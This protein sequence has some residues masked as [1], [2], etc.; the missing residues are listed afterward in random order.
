MQTK[1]KDRDY[2]AEPIEWRSTRDPEF[3][4]ESSKDG[5]SLMIR[6]NDF[7][8]EH[9]YS[10]LVEGDPLASFDDWPR[11]WT[12]NEGTINSSNSETGL[13]TS[14]GPESSHLLV[15]LPQ[16]PI[17][18]FASILTNLNEYYSFNEHRRIHLSFYDSFRERLARWGMKDHPS[19]NPEHEKLIKSG[20]EA[21]NNWRIQH[22]DVQPNLSGVDLTGAQ[23]S[24]INLSRAYLFG[25]DLRKSDLRNARLDNA[26]LSA[27]IL[28]EANLSGAFLTN[29]ILTLTN[30]DYANLDS[31]FLSEIKSFR[32]SFLGAT[33]VNTSFSESSLFETDFSGADLRECRLTYTRFV[34]SKFR[35]ANLFS[36]NVYGMSAWDMDVSNAFQDNLLISRQG[37]PR[38]LVDN[39]EFAQLVL[40]LLQSQ[41]TQHVINSVNSK[42]VIVLGHFLPT[43]NSVLRTITSE[44]RAHNYTPIIVEFGPFSPHMMAHNVGLLS[45]LARFIIVDISESAE[46]VPDLMNLVTKISIP[47]QLTSEGSRES[48]SRIKEQFDSDLMLSGAHYKDADELST[49]LRQRVIGEA[50]AKAKELSGR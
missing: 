8:D 46:F 27:A 23:L 26:N 14:M 30:F 22:P 13:N 24:G 6:V 40:L 42:A 38:I 16:L 9:L 3:P 15:T 35:D 48:H 43:R 21:W 49:L 33:L 17:E 10:L 25:A 50:E 19:A 4:Y 5:I 45:R 11:E 39:I 28:T 20:V 7:P 36:C 18:R 12:R 37:E 34:S 41:G 29:S 1:S 47:I 44:L 2:L 31:A 32:S